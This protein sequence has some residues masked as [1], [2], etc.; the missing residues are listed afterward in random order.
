MPD[1]S[2]Q[3]G[4][5]ER[6]L[7]GYYPMGT[8]KCV[9]VIKDEYDRILITHEADSENATEASAFLNK[10]KVL[11]LNITYVF[12]DYSKSYISAIKE[13]FPK[14]KFQADH[15]YTAKNIW[16][17]LKKGL[18]EY[19]REVKSTGEKEKNEE[20]LELATQLWKMSVDIVEKA[21]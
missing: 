1:L 2:A 18:L 17:H 15:F 5:F 19:R 10:L 12:S 9:M 11:G 6:L 21:F 8:N 3:E 4:V 7:D 16:K 14:A 13:V 20:L